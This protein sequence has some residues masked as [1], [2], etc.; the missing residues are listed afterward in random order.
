M[1]GWFVKLSDL[2]VISRVLTVKLT[3]PFVVSQAP[4]VDLM[5]LFVVLTGPVVNPFP[6][7]VTSNAFVRRNDDAVREIAPAA[8]R[9]D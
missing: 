9:F 3:P 6:P 4:F 5:L 1:A 2:P 8:C 7:F